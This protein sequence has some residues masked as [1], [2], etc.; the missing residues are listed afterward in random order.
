[1]KRLNWA[2][3]L[4]SWML[5]VSSAQARWEI[6]RTPGGSGLETIFVNESSAQGMWIVEKQGGLYW[7]TWNSTGNTFN[8]CGSTSEFDAY[9]TWFMGADEH[10][11]SASNIPTTIAATYQGTH[12]YTYSSGQWNEETGC[13]HRDR[14][15]KWHDAALVGDASGTPAFYA[16]NFLIVNAAVWSPTSNDYKKGIYLVCQDAYPLPGDRPPT[17]LAHEYQY[18]YR[19]LDDAC[20][21]YAYAYYKDE[22]SGYFNFQRICINGTGYGINVAQPVYNDFQVSGVNL[23]D[24]PFAGFYQYKTGNTRH[25]FLVANEGTEQNPDWHVWHREATSALFS[26]TDW[27]R[28]Y[29]ITTNITDFN[30]CQGLA[31]RKAA[32]PTGTYRIY[33]VVPNRGLAVL[34]SSQ[35]TSQE[36]KYLNYDTGDN[37]QYLK[38]YSSRSMNMNPPWW[39]STTED[40]VIIPTGHADVHIAKGI[41]FNETNPS[42]SQYSTLENWGANTSVHGTA[43]KGGS[44]VSGAVVDGTTLYFIH[45]ATGIYSFNPSTWSNTYAREGINPTVTSSTFY[46][47]SDV[48]FNIRC[49]SFSPFGETGKLYLGCGGRFYPGSGTEVLHGGI[50]YTEPSVAN[51]QMHATSTNFCPQYQGPNAMTAD[52]TSGHEVLYYATVENTSDAPV[53]IEPD[54]ERFS[55]YSNLYV[56][57]SSTGSRIPLATTAASGLNEY[58]LV[59]WSGNPSGEWFWGTFSC[60]RPHPTISSAV[61]YGLSSMFAG[62]DWGDPYGYSGGSWTPSQTDLGGGLG[63]VRKSGASWLAPNVIFSCNHASYYPMNIYFFEDVLDMIVEQ[64]SSGSADPW[65]DLIILAATGAYPPMHGTEDFCRYGGL[66]KIKW[67]ESNAAWQ[68]DKVTPV[69][70]SEYKFSGLSTFQDPAVT[71]VDSVQVGTRRFYFCTTAGQEYSASDYDRPLSLLWYQKKNNIDAITAAGWHKIPGS[72]PGTVR[73]PD[74]QT[75]GSFRDMANTGILAQCT[76]ANVINLFV[77]GPVATRVTVSS[78]SINSAETWSGTILLTEDRSITAGGTLTLDNANGNT[79]ITAMD[80]YTI[81]VNGGNLLVANASAQNKVLLTAT[82][83]VDHWGGIQ[84][85]AF[86]DSTMHTLDYLKIE[87][88]DR[89][90][91]VEPNANAYVMLTINHCRFEDD[92]TAISAQ[93][94]KVM[95]ITNCTIVDSKNDGIYLFNLP[96]SVPVG[97]DHRVANCEITGGRVC[98]IHSSTCGS[99]LK[100]FQNYIHDNLT[101]GTSNDAG[102]TCINS[103]PQ[104]YNNEVNEPSGFALGTA[105]SSAPSLLQETNNFKSSAGQGYGV[106]HARNGFPTL[107]G[108]YNN[109]IHQNNGKL[110]RDDSDPFTSRT[111]RRNYWDYSGGPTDDKFYPGDAGSYDYSNYLTAADSMPSFQYGTASLGDS[112]AYE[113]LEDALIAESQGNFTSAYGTLIAMIQTYPEVEDA[114]CQ[115]LPHMLIVGPG[116]SLNPERPAR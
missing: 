94:A 77:G 34:R 74:P 37:M 2:I 90:I 84:I 35:G 44:Y 114:I 7:T 101:A 113:L 43:Y 108:A 56:L 9:Y 88:A 76:S 41:N 36:E 63:I 65:K 89:G 115:A 62:I 51:D 24:I 1:M 21:R 4:A 70:T 18:I 100:I 109:V 11:T 38:N 17:S 105:V 85:K 54:F 32:T 104:I 5:A 53:P 82:D 91:T 95:R 72:F 20:G 73:Y 6:H 97:Y 49:G 47:N 57:E 29:D 102:I 55:Y 87:K 10:I 75:G 58:Y 40:Y 28:V 111:V 48:M 19:D 116:L 71:G 67:N 92:S 112:A 99:S 39:S 81:T 60:L 30:G 68:V 31:A 69:T 27:A 98:G 107:N 66:F 26:A 46:D 42:V 33:L 3:V 45:D 8:P 59:K 23:T 14:Y 80:D 12:R 64:Y 16:D 110:I 52:A 78:A 86:N 83:G 96:A 15:F 13:P 103:N 79:Q 61:V 22:S 106:I 25:Q 93:D 50:W